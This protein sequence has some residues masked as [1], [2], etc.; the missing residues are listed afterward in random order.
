MH[1]DS[2]DNNN[3]S[4]NSN[5][6]KGYQEHLKPNGKYR[7]LAED[8]NCITPFAENPDQ[9]EPSVQFRSDMKDGQEVNLDLRR[10]RQTS[11]ESS[12]DLHTLHHLAELESV[13]REGS[14]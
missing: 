14:D 9:A 12:S 4:N 8:D 10:G 7:E 1:N 3:N 11:P 2:G 6:S 13:K 5:H